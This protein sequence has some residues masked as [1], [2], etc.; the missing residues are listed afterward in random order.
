M[1][2]AFPNPRWRITDLNIADAVQ[3]SIGVV[4][5]AVEGLVPIYRKAHVLGSIPV[6]ASIFF[7]WNLMGYFKQRGYPL[8]S[9]IPVE[10]HILFTMGVD[11]RGRIL[12]T[13]FS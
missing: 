1:A 8:L 9:K 6:D 13:T 3:N 5:E 10:I 7:H 2:V 11:G 4:A 12:G